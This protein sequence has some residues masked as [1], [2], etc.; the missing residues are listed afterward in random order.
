MIQERRTRLVSLT[1]CIR[2]KAILF[3]KD[4]FAHHI[5]DRPDPKVFVF[6]LPNFAEYL[7]K[8]LM[9]MGKGCVDSR[10]SFRQPAL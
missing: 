2:V 8:V 7:D 10:D 3:A 1:K 4:V 6:G 9:G 5:V